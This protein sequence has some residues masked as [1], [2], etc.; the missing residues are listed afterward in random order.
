MEISPHRN[1]HIVHFSQDERPFIGPLFEFIANGVTKGEGIVLMLERRHADLLSREL[2][3]SLLRRICQ[4]DAHLALERFYPEG[5][6]DLILFQD[7][8][9]ET[10]GKLKK[11]YPRLRIYSDLADLLRAQG[12]SEKALEL[13]AHWNQ[14]LTQNESITLLRGSCD[15]G[16][17]TSDRRSA[18]VVPHSQVF[19]SWDVE[20]GKPQEP[21]RGSSGIAHDVL[22]PLTVIV[23]SA[24][25]LASI[26]DEGPL[27][28]DPL[29]QRHLS[30][31]FEAS[32][33]ISKLMV[34]LRPK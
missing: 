21:K 11:K 18:I 15:W 31:L 24:T 27:R 22:N 9:Q 2:S 23:G 25:V 12:S 8:L 20:I 16:A 29:V 10:I 34:E 19:G 17:L 7:F 33:R 32:E 5:E 14:I 1:D 30:S 3:P 26:I 4:I 6:L 28:D 13:E